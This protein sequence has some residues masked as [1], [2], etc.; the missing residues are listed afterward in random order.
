[1]TPHRI[2]P[3]GIALLMTLI[4]AALLAVL[5][6]AFVTVNRANSSI[7]GN[8]V[9]RQNAYNAC[10]S[11]L[12]YAWG[13][14]ERDQAFGADGFPDGV[15]TVNLPITSPEV[16]IRIHGNSEEPE[17]PD[18]NYIEGEILASGDSFE[19]RLVNNLGNRDVKPA[20]FL[21]DVPGRCTRLEILGNSGRK[22]LTLSSVL[23]KAPYVDSSA[24]SSYDM[25]IE[26]SDNGPQNQWNL[27]SKDPY[28]NQ[29]RSNMS[30][31]GPSAVDGNLRF[32]DP[33]RGGVAMAHDD[34]ELGGVSVTSNPTFLA[35][36]QEAARGSLQTSTAE[37]DV[38]DLNRNN[39]AFPPTK[40]EVPPGDMEMSVVEV[41]EWEE[42]EDQPGQFQKKVFLHN[43]IEH[44]GNL[45]VSESRELKSTTI[46]DA[47]GDDGVQGI[48][49][50]IDPVDFDDRPIL[51]S[52]G[53]EDSEHKMVADLPTGAITLSPG[54][55]FDVE[56]TLKIKQNEEAPQAH[57]LFGYEFEGEWAV[58]KGGSNAMDDA[59]ANSAVLSTQGDL[60]IDG[61][62]T[63]FGS[64]YADQDVDLRAKSGLR[65]EQDLAV[66]V[67]GHKI[68]FTAEE[69]PDSSATNTLS[70]AEFIAFGDALGPNYDQYDGWF[71]LEQM[72]QI[73]HIGFDPENPTGL[74]SKRLDENGDFYWNLIMQDL[75]RNDSPPNWASLG[76]EWSGRLNLEQFVRLQ[77]YAKDRSSS[78]LNMPG[79]AF[80]SVTSIINTR[81]ST[82]SG[83]A[84]RMNLSMSDYMQEE[85]ATIADVYFVGLVHAGEGGFN[86]DAY[87]AS[88]LFEG[89]LVSQGSMRIA[90][91]K[92]VDFVY[93]RS[94]L[95]DVV[96]QYVGSSRANLD[97]VYYRLQ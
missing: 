58:F 82:Y 30:I 96:K 7:T 29:V 66:A 59:A 93:N 5:T 36:S 76:P 1:M 28:V 74:R 9:T 80:D 25:E 60:F 10:L 49:I 69:P 75:E 40:V 68:S 65:A 41:H 46:H 73:P 97:Q 63:G 12:H 52:D 39:L 47:R 37:I 77:E 43:S 23:R 90:N 53:L 34:I 4:V 24:L 70:Q 6:G 21:G 11:G 42:L 88:M 8:V 22:R 13:E 54:T 85:I 61:I 95:D 71:N 64:L 45:W 86:A 92:S 35:D 16:K 81:I 62:T 17:N 72:A 55:T 78:W 18:L 44:A 19:V 87:G 3:H 38:P 14:L 33:P 84:H 2:V 91:T 31:A 51:Y 20:S 57:L 67:H 50:P 48:D 94:Y 26:L 15:R 89:S 27:R 83:W 56:G 32:S 79:P